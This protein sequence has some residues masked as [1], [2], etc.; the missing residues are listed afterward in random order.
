M[1]KSSSPKTNYYNAGPQMSNFDHGGYL[2]VRPSVKQVVNT[3]DYKQ[4]SRAAVARE[5]KGEENY[6]YEELLELYL[7]KT[8]AGARR[9]FDHYVPSIDDLGPEIILNLKLVNA[10]RYS[11]AGVYL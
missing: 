6:N 11:Q 7:A 8:Q 4:F 5:G 10:Y 9:P 2:R 3:F 1:M